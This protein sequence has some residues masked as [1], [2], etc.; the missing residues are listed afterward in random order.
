M[1]P[2]LKSPLLSFWSTMMLDLIHFNQFLLITNTSDMAA[3]DV[4]GD[5]DDNDI[6]EYL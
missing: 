5:D 4:N 2:G 3:D 6:L 1:P